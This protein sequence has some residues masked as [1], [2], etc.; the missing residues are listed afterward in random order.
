[1]NRFLRKDPIN[2]RRSLSFSELSYELDEGEVQ[3]SDANICLDFGPPD[4]AVRF[5]D[6]QDRQIRGSQF[7]S[8]GFD[9]GEKPRPPAPH[10]AP[11]VRP[12]NHGHHANL[13]AKSPD[14]YRRFGGE[15]MDW[16]ISHS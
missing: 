3:K 14:A 7:R 9:P 10:R 2:F 5:R 8:A 6:R 15:K 12:E 4:I 1:M 11:T 13:T 16:L